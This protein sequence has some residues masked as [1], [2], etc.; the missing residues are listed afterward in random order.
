MAPEV[1]AEEVA[2]VFDELAREAIFA[3]RIK[4]P[5]VDA[6]QVAAALGMVVATN[7][8]QAERGRFV[9]L[10]SPNPGRGESRSSLSNRP[11]RPSILLRPEPRQERRQWAVA[12]EIGEELAWSVFERLSLDPR[13]LAPGAREWAANQFAGRLLLP[14][15]WFRQAGVSLDWDLRRLKRRFA[16]ASHESIARRTLAFSP[17]IVVTVFDQGAMTW[18]L[19]NLNSP[20]G[21]LRP[22]ER[23]CW[24]R[25][26]AKNDR[27]VTLVAR[28]GAV[29]VRGWAIHEGP[30]RREI[31]RMETL[32]GLDS[33]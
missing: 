28:G 5:P 8:A 7:R 14:T 12:H 16:T 11:D 20:P 26:R 32:S 25:T 9:R 29:R 22:I 19:S 18:R 21:D 23:A 15:D 24:R 27:R 3:A 1:I 31:T 13:A 33:D 30:W 2:V 4:R 6:A 10:R 17:R